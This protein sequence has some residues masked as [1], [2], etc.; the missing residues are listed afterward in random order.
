MTS[1]I[2]LREPEARDI[3]D[4]IRFG[5]ENLAQLIAEA[6][7][8]EAWKALGYKSWGEYVEREFPFNR[9]TAYNLIDQGRAMKA[10]SE[11]AGYPVEVTIQQARTFKKLPAIQKQGITQRLMSGADAR[12]TLRE[13]LPVTRERVS[14]DFSDDVYDDGQA[15]YRCRHCQRVGPLSMGCVSVERAA[16]D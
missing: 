16:A 7:D 8:K 13:E 3:T 5:M 14:V 15:L 12:Q 2:L 10:L 9:A 11:A 6:H 1:V 4:R